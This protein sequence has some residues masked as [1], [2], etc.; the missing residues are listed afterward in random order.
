MTPISTYN[1]KIEP[2]KPIQALVC[3]FTVAVRLTL[4][5]IDIT[6]SDSKNEPSVL[7][8][9]KPNEYSSGH[10]ESESDADSKQEYES[11]EKKFKDQKNKKSNR[12][13]D[14]TEDTGETEYVLCTLSP[15]TQCQQTFDLIIHSDEEI[16]FLVTGP[17]TIHVSGNYL[18]TNDSGT[19][20]EDSEIYSDLEFSDRVEELLDSP[21]N[22]NKRL[23]EDD[24]EFQKKKKLRGDEKKSVKFLDN[25]EKQKATNDKKKPSKP[26]GSSD[27]KET[28]EKK[29]FSKQTLSGG[30][31][32]EDRKKGL[33]SVAK[34]GSKVSIRYIGKLKGGK[35]FDKNTS[36]KPFSFV[37]GKG[38]CIKGF[39]IGVTGMMVNGERRIIIPSSMG[40]GSQSLP[41]IPPNSELCFDIKLLSI[42]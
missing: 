35:I 12:D 31:V 17:H 15:K 40:Y 9:L 4:A 37:L 27:Y 1:L 16:F 38:D 21:D 11:K 30:V 28:P 6:A 41:D 24:V 33:G 2:N 8:I 22:S 13:D 32:V 3:D 7:K 29:T 23:V 18:D 39:D 20:S 25:T 5:A 14:Y 36:G 42:K 34:K 10:S 19:D 26:V